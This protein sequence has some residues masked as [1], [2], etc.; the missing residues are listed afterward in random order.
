MMDI[1][2]ILFILAM[3]VCVIIYAFIGGLLTSI[4]GWWIAIPFFL[5]ALVI[6]F[7]I[8]KVTKWWVWRR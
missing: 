2:D 5:G 3:C 6:P 7:L 8:V 4:L 1:K